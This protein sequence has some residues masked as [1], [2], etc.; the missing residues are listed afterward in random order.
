MPSGNVPQYDRL[1]PT[2]PRNSISSQVAGKVAMKKITTRAIRALNTVCYSSLHAVDVRTRAFHEASDAVQASSPGSYAWLIDARRGTGVDVSTRLEGSAAVKDETAPEPDDPRKPESPPDL[3]KRSW[4]YT[5]KMAFAEFNRDQCADL[6]AA[7]TFYAIAAVFP[8]FI[9]LAALVGLIGESPSTAD[10]LV[11]LIEDLGQTDAAEQLRGPITELAQVAW[12]GTGT[13]ARYLGALW[14]ASAYVGAFGRAMNRIYEV[15]EGRP[16][17]KL[18]P[19]NISSACRDRRC[20]DPAAQ[21]R[22]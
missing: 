17:W 22:A 21:R 6:A 13:R 2:F 12:R 20:C 15:D 8:A 7:L 11:G 16:V 5:A 14:S 9:V 19:L 3:H 10:A 4:L 1:R 18:R